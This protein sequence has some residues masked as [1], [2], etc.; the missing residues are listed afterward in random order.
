MDRQS[1]DYKT[2]GRKL[3][4]R[5]DRAAA[6]KALSRHL[7][8]E[9]NDVDAW[10]MLAVA[11]DDKGQRADCYRQVLRVDP[12]NRLASHQLA[13]IQEAEKVEESPHTENPSEE[14]VA[15]KSPPPSRPSPS[16]P[17]KPASF[18]LRPK[19]VAALGGFFAIVGTFLP[20]TVLYKFNESSRVPLDLSYG[21]S[22]IQGLF[23]LLTSAAIVAVAFVHNTR[24]GKPSAPLA[25]FLAGVGL[26]MGIYW[27]WVTLTPLEVS[28][29]DVAAFFGETTYESTEAGSGFTISMI[30]LLI[31]FLSGLARNRNS[32]TRHVTATGT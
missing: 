29:G 27:W 4:E 12:S 1:S 2:V 19:H 24:E 7:S 3:L 9:S 18:A 15:G 17:E 23:V 21:I 31:A 11:L 5:G 20:W 32:N 10:F 28:Q 16:L 14:L 13:Q 30:S 22:S 26:L 8:I 6:A 25:A